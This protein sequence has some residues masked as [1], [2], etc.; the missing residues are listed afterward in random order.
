MSV[1]E[2]VDLP[3]VAVPAARLAQVE[4]LR[5]RAEHALNVLLGEGPVAIPRGGSLAAAAHRVTVPDS[6]PSTLIARRP[7]VEAAE[8]AY[9]AATADL[10]ALEAKS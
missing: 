3:Q 9:A 10:S 1:D 8:R 4:Q 6:V 7:D 2:A 5:S